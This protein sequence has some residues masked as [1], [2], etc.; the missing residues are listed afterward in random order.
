MVNNF[1]SEY[2][3]MDWKRSDCLDHADF[4]KHADYTAEDL[5]SIPAAKNVLR[6]LNCDP[7]VCEEHRDSADLFKK[8]TNC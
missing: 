1:F 6:L 4:L 7:K 3:N 8:C 2:V 5:P